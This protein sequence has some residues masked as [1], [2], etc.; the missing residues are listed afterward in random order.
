MG[1][2]AFA[3]RLKQIREKN[4]I[5]QNELAKAVGVTSNTISSYEKSDIEG[6]GKKPTLE[7]AQA[8]A[9]YFNVS[10]DWLCGRVD[11]LNGGYTNLTAG[12]Y[13]KSLVNI[14]M[15]TSCTIS[16]EQTIN[17]KNCSITDFIRKVS[18]L[19]KVYR[20]G[21]IP[22]DLFEVCIEK[23]INDYDKMYIIFGNCILS[24]IEKDEVIHDIEIMCGVDGQGVTPGPYPITLGAAP[25]D[26]F[27]GRKVIL[28]ISQREAEQIQSGSFDSLAEKQVQDNGEH[29]PPKE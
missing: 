5:K 20:A 19:I 1:L 3:Q 17:I 29:N 10:L 7:N 9:E 28:Y 26:G 4:G 8:I 2:T 12:Q 14:L 18:D 16:S 25:F 15:E 27:Y 21:S 23:L 22:E 6:N 24:S 11:A 13:F